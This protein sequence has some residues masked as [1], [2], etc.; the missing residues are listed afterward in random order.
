MA[1]IARSTFKALI[2]PGFEDNN[3]IDWASFTLRDTI[4]IWRRGARGLTVAPHGGEQLA[5]LGGEDREVAALEQLVTIPK[6]AATLSF[7]HIIASEDE[8][9]W[10]F[11]GVVVN[12][13]MVER[14]DLCRTTSTRTWQRRTVNLQAY[15]GE[16]V[17]LQIRAE[18]DAYATSSLYVDDVVV[19]PNP[20]DQEPTSPQPGP[21]PAVAKPGVPRT[22]RP[23]SP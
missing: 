12:D 1:L 23:Q 19:G 8:C 6:D 20:S 15:A 14:F 4:N 7:W 21:A 11:G 17:H 18:T 5:W 2:N 9:G 16:T 3:S 13:V 10:D 22:M